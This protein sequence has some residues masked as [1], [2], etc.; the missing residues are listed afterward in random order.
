MKKNCNRKQNLY[1]YRL[2]L[3]VFTRKNFLLTTLG[4]IMSREFQFDKELKNLK[5]RASPGHI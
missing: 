2:D 1:F 5:K 3:K 4:K